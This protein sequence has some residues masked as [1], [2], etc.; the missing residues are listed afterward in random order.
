MKYDWHI[1][2]QEIHP[3]TPRPCFRFV[4]A[5]KGHEND[6]CT[7]G[8]MFGV[9]SNDAAV[10]SVED[11]F[12]SPAICTVF[13]PIS[14]G[15]PGDVEAKDSNLHDVSHYSAALKVRVG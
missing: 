1:S 4:I 8:Q 12:G 11:A 2:F 14:A 5:L 7:I 13:F 3:S 15:S 10:Y 9:H 6:K